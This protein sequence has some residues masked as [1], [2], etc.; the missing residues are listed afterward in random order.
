MKD[1]VKVMVFLILV[2]ITFYS[3]TT[4]TTYDVV[5]LNSCKKILFQKTNIISFVIFT[6]DINM[7]QILFFEGE[8]TFKCINKY[9]FTKKNDKPKKNNHV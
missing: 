3:C 4:K 7:N 8:K 5:K 2:C 9:N 1:F 6:N